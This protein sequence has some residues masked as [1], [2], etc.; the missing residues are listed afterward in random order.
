MKINKEKKGISLI[1]LTITLI[2]MV[3]LAGAII[4]NIDDTKII[5]Q[6][7]RGVTQSNVATIKEILVTAK[8]NWRVNE[9][10]L[11]K[12]GYNS[13]RAYVES[14][15]EKAGIEIGTNG[16]QVNL[17]EDGTLEIYYN[18]E[19]PSGFVKSKV[20]TEDEVS[21]GL[22]IYEGAYPV[23][24][25]N[26]EE[27]RKTRNQYVWVP[28]PNVD[29]FERKDWG[30]NKED[31]IFTDLT[32]YNL[33]DA[34]E[35]AGYAAMKESVSKY[36]GFY[37]ARY[38]AGKEE[39]LLVSKKEATP[40]NEISWNNAKLACETLTSDYVVGHL[41][42]GEEWDAALKFISKTDK[43]YALNSIEKGWY[44]DNFSSGNPNRLTGKDVGTNAA[45]KV[46]NIYDMGGNLLE[47]TMERSSTSNCVMRGGWT[48]DEGS[49]SPAAE[50]GARGMSVDNTATCFRSA[51]YIK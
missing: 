3:I 27:A 17:T 48:K 46:C 45:N 43:T 51:I 28:V 38:E 33:A 21:E 23:N 25:S 2:V 37:I 9:A 8:S 47:W 19:I 24:D 30:K 7:T 35:A 13:F 1:V 50:R 31:T 34:N 16:G 22:V 5:N 14:M 20:A 11:R 44:K 26:V 18:P 12:E 49:V 4:L 10:K 32:S 41:I 42:Y 29:D 15:Y 6:A 36:G 39:G 40:W